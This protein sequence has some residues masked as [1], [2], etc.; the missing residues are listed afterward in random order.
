MTEEDLINLEM[1]IMCEFTVPGGCYLVNA[2]CTKR[3]NKYENRLR[4]LLI[5]LQRCNNVGFIKLICVHYERTII[6]TLYKL[7]I[8][9]NNCMF[10]K[11]Y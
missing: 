9:S 10:F 4:N 5:T 3:I 11:Q 1:K 8:R 7:F 6:N 2:E